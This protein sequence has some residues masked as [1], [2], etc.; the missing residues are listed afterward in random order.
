MF[1]L[2]GC[3]LCRGGICI[4]S[5]VCSRDTE[6]GANGPVVDVSTGFR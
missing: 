2:N 5:N 3:V 6:S 4:G 1:A